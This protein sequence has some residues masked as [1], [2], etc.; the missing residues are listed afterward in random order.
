[1]NADFIPCALCRAL[2]EIENQKQD[3][4]VIYDLSTDGWKI[5]CDSCMLN[6]SFRG[7]PYMVINF[8]ALKEVPNVR[9]N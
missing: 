1:M 6:C 4:S 7:I 5:I 9:Q 2:V 8:G 3:V